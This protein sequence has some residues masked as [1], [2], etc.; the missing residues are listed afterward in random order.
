MIDLAEPPSPTELTLTEVYGANGSA[1][2]DQG[3]TL[4]YSAAA[5]DVDGDGRIDLI[6]NEMTGNGAGG[7]PRN[8][9]NLILLS[10][11]ILGLEPA[12]VPAIPTSALPV[13]GVLLLLGS[14]FHSIG[15]PKPRVR[16]EG[17]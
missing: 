8:V 15:K 2:G 4:C 14:L 1:P 13:L 3:D 12:P 6:T 9:G 5:A 7:S 10:G 11:A 17:S 16:A